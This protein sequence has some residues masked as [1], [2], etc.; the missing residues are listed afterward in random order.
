MWKQCENI[1]FLNTDVIYFNTCSYFKYHTLTINNIIYISDNYGKSFY[2][3]YKFPNDLIYC[4]NIY[5]SKLGKYQSIP[6]Y[7]N[8]LYSGIIRGRAG[9]GE[10][11]GPLFFFLPKN[12]PQSR[13]SGIWCLPWCLHHIR[14]QEGRL[15]LIMGPLTWK[16]PFTASK[17]ASEKMN[18]ALR[19]LQKRCRFEVFFP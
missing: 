14:P 15:W 12:S 6:I 7:S 11:R 16:M 1:N 18:Y 2:I 5:I 3:S 10:T 13:G 17:S 4:G 9:S 19:K 8:R